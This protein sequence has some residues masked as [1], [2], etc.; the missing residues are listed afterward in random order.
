ML[1]ENTLRSIPI[2]VGCKLPAYQASFPESFFNSGNRIFVIRHLVYQIDPLETV[3]RRAVAQQVRQ[4]PATLPWRSYS[5]DR[6]IL[7]VTISPT[8]S[9]RRLER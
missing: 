7:A 3:P 8:R 6:S 5:S 1:K 4:K 9:G 2:T